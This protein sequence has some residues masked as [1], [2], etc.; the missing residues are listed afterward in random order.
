LIRP[1]ALRALDAP[2]GT[3]ALIS[4]ELIDRAVAH[5]R[6]SPRRRMI[7]PLHRSADEAMH[8]MLNAVQPG[9]YIRPH[10]HLDPPKAEAWIVL[11]GAAAFFAFEDDGRIREC[12]RLEAGGEA[13]GVDLA[14]GIFHT[15][16]ALAPDTVIYEVKTGPYSEKTDKSFAPWAP[17][18]GAPDA[19]RYLDGL[20]GQ[21][22][23]R[24]GGDR[25]AVIAWRPPSLRTDRLVLRGYEPGDAPAIFAYASDAETTRY[26]AWDRHRSIDDARLFLNGI[27]A[28]SYVAHRLD[29]AICRA[30]EPSRAIGGVGVYPQKGP[31]RVMEL[32]YIIGRPH[33]GQGLGPEAVRG[34]IDHAF[35]TTDVERIVAPIFADNAR[36]RRLAEKLGFTLDGVMRSALMFRGRRWDEAVYSILRS[37][38]T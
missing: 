22:A 32:G 29:Y 30:G 1:P 15:F 35:R 12:R 38:W 26:M 17:E 9:S 28:D 19:S 8:R 4:N 24:V 34:L 3:L 36:S 20:V 10:R 21:Y 14:P 7:Q 6:Q 33:W 25:L 27:V 11:R 2:T 37:E 23:E 13:V 31:H 16:A 18:E 5:S